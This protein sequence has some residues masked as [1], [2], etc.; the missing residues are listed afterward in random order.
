MRLPEL[1]CTCYL[2]FEFATG[3]QVFTMFPYNDDVFRT[4]AKVSL[5]RYLS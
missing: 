5:I 2:S 4:I 3:E 1:I